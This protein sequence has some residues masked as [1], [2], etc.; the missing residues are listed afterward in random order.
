MQKE[1]LEKIIEGYSW[2]KVKKYNEI[3]TDEY[4]MINGS[5]Y[6]ELLAHHEKE[7]GFLINKCRELAKL[8]LD[9]YV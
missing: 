6:N 8:C 4:E 2:I 5:C 1:E 3:I 9:K 7:T